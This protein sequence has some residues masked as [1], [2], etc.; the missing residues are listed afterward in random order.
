MAPFEEVIGRHRSHGAGY[1]IRHAIHPHLGAEPRTYFET[2]RYAD[3]V[4]DSSRAIDLV[5]AARVGDDR[6]QLGRGSSNV[7]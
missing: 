2:L 3:V 4:S 5:V 6:E 7:D 1:A